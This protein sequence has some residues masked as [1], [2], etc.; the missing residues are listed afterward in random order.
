MAKSNDSLHRC[1]L[2]ILEVRLLGRGDL[3]VK[4]DEY[5]APALLPSWPQDVRN[6]RM[7]LISR[8]PPQSYP[9]RCLRWDS[10]GDRYWAL[11]PVRASVD[12]QYSDSACRYYCYL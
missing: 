10:H 4:A 9:C 11:R 6:C 12:S 5:P 3:Q 8:E 1:R 2:L 7:I